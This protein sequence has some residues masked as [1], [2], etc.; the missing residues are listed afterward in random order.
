M[1]DVMGDKIFLNWGQ[2]GILLCFDLG[3]PDVKPFDTTPYPPQ[4]VG[5][6]YLRTGRLQGG[7]CVSMSKSG[8]VWGV[9]GVV[10]RRH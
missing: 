5:V 4:A 9:K 10:M 3:V 1:S 7:G 2:Q 8:T 6:M